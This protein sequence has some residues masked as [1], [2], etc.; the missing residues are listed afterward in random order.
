MPAAEGST[1]T[2][3]PSI[4]PSPP[5]FSPSSASSAGGALANCPCSWLAVY[6]GHGGTE[7]SAF[8]HW[9]LH[10]HV[11][12]AL[13]NCKE[14]ILANLD[15]GGSPDKKPSPPGSDLPSD[16]FFPFS[17]QGAKAA[18][19]GSASSDAKPLPGAASTASAAT[20][21]EEEEDL[22]V[23]DE[24]T[25]NLYPDEALLEHD[26]IDALVCQAL[27]SSFLAADQEFLASRGEVEAGS[28]ATTVLLLGNRIYCAN[29]GDSRTVLCRDGTAVALSKD[30][31]PTR[32]DELSRILGAGGFVFSKRIMGQLAVSRSFGDGQYKK[33]LA[34]ILADISEQTRKEGVDYN[35][36]LVIAEPEISTSTLQAG[37]DDF[38][39]LACDGLFD[40]MTDQ[41][42]CEF[43]LSELRRHG[44]PAKAADRIS[45]HAIEELNSRDN[46]SVLLAVFKRSF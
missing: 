15:A 27:E 8:L 36:P 39:L 22:K 42:A 14:Q 16:P 26:A 37:N 7:V 3:P 44:D 46:V 28:T 32:E 29:V 12:K 5:S 21:E 34:D 17:P 25:L 10:E 11:A 45:D 30:H 38:L 19:G 6:D 9:R 40:V 4:L 23:V 41:Q 35:A 33:G 13:D 18:P 1:S 31:K 24:R 43:I 20:A 2:T